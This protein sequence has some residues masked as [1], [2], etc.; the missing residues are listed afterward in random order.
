MAVG[1]KLLAWRHFVSIELPS[2][3][4]WQQIHTIITKMYY[5]NIILALLIAFNFGSFIWAAYKFFEFQKE[6]GVPQKT[7]YLAYLILPCQAALVITI[8]LVKLPL[9]GFIAGIL[10]CLVS[11]LLFRACLRTHGD[12]ALTGAYASNLPVHLVQEGPYRWIRH[13]FYTSYLLTYIGGFLA[14]P[15]WWALPL[16][17]IPYFIYYHASSFE[18]KKFSQS[19][20]S[21]NYSLY[22]QQAGRFLPKLF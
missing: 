13:P 9:P 3:A 20:L 7:K 18:E 5:L 22:R 14:A 19:T 6:E 12:K 17:L 15:Y 4:F 11:Y 10:L 16:V 21:E 1:T 2:I 8:L